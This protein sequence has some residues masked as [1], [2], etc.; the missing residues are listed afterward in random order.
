MKYKINYTCSRIID[1]DNPTMAFEDYCGDCFDKMPREVTKEELT[2]MVKW[3]SMD[4]FCELF[5]RFVRTETKVE[6]V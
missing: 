2:E 4:D 3:L 6:K 1:L 5:G